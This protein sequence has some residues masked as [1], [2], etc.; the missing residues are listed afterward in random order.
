MTLEYSFFV[1]LDC[2]G[3]KFTLIKFTLITA[4]D[5]NNLERD[6]GLYFAKTI[7]IATDVNT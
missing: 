7:M 6:W 5:V 4:T 1:G 2:C 3:E